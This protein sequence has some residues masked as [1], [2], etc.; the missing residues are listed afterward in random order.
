[1]QE[2]R[3]AKERAE[4]QV[5][6][7]Q[8]DIKKAHKKNE[9]KLE[10][11]LAER[12]AQLCDI[13][14]NYKEKYNKLK[15]QF[16]KDDDLNTIIR[17]DEISADEVDEEKLDED[18][19]R[20]QEMLQRE[21]DKMLKFKHDLQDLPPATVRIREGLKYYGKETCKDWFLCLLVV[22]NIAA[23]AA[24]CITGVIEKEVLLE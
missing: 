14:A 6:S 4:H 19:R 24:A 13:M 20:Q 15:F 7:I 8:Q 17:P 3:T 9:K 11:A 10:Q 1:M 21:M 23:F 16:E 5:N 22:I 2:V 18:E 12:R